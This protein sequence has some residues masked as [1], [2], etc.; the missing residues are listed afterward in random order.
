MFF[1]HATPNEFKN[2][3]LSFGHFGYV[4]E[5]ISVTVIKF[6][7]LEKRLRKASFS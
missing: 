4:F 3:T 7:P 5:E 6:L 2:A 1:V